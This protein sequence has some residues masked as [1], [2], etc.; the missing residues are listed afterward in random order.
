MAFFECGYPVL[1]APFGEKTILHLLNCLSTF[2]ENQL[3]DQEERWQKSLVLNGIQ[4][5]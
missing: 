5:R 2:V 1:L 4:E 3:I